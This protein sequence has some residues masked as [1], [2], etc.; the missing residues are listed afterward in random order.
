MVQYWIPAITINIINIV[1]WWWYLLGLQTKPLNIS[2]FFYCRLHRRYYNRFVTNGSLTNCVDR[3]L[4]P[5]TLLTADY[6]RWHRL[7]TVDSR[8]LLSWLSLTVQTNCLLRRR[9]LLLLLLLGGWLQPDG[10][11]LSSWLQ[12]DYCLR[13]LAH[14]LSDSSPVLFAGSPDYCDDDYDSSHCRDPT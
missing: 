7:F 6:F 4:F 5:S 11:R 13:R 3:S 14:R 12:T 8:Q 10:F 9:R 1:P 2:H